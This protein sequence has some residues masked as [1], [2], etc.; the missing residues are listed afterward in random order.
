VQPGSPSWPVRDH[1]L[2]WCRWHGEVYRARD[3]RLGRDVAIKVLPAESPVIL[4]VSVGSSRKLGRLRSR[5]P[6]PSL[7]STTSALTRV[8]RISSPSC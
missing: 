8:P 2:N 3:T 6:Q 1:C 4:S 7:L 5:S